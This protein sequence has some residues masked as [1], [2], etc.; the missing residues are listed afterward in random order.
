MNNKTTE[1]MYFIDTSIPGDEG[2]YFKYIILTEKQL[3]KYINWFK[4]YDWKG[5]SN[6]ICL[7]R[8]Y[9]YRQYR[10][11]KSLVLGALTKAK[12]ITETKIQF[13]KDFCPG[14]RFDTLP[15]IIKQHS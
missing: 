15:E 2:K 7:Y 12:T 1:P 13:L 11:T 10:Y 14:T 6:S 9:L 3:H 8:H 4:S 5:N